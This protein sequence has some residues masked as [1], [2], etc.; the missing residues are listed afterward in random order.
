MTKIIKRLNLSTAIRRYISKYLSGQ[1]GDN[2]INENQQLILQLKRADLWDYLFVEHPF[3]ENEMDQL[4]NIFKFTLGE[5]MDLY[6]KL[7]TDDKILQDIKNSLTK[8]NKKIEDNLKI[9]QQIKQDIPTSS[10]QEKGK[11]KNKTK[12]KKDNPEFKEFGD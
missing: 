10:T 9:N 8:N 4:N 1:R 6:E 12:D 3:F 2:E 11:E 7:G 5:V